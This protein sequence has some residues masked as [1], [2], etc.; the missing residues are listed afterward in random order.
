MLPERSNILI[1]SRDNL[2]TCIYYT[3]IINK[4]YKYATVSVCKTV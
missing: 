4:S 2:T 1:N 3:V